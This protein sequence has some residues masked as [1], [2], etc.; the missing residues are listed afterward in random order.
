MRSLIFNAFAP[1]IQ[2][3]MLE[4]VGEIDGSASRPDLIIVESLERMS[5]GNVHETVQCLLHSCIA[6]VFLISEFCY[7]FLPL[8]VRSSVAAFLLT[9]SLLMLLFESLF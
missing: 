1:C 6:K 9:L 4:C 7:A 2:S 3:E 5:G 8:K